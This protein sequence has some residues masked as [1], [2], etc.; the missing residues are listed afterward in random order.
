MPRA[1]SVGKRS[2]QRWTGAAQTRFCV[3]TPA[4]VAGRS[5]TTSARSSRSRSCRTPHLTPAKRK[6]RGSLVSCMVVFVSPR[7]ESSSG[8]LPSKTRVAAKQL[9]LLQLIQHRR[10]REFKRAGLVVPQA[11]ARLVVLQR[12]AEIVLTID[13]HP[14]SVH[15]NSFEIGRSIAVFGFR[16]F[17]VGPLFADAHQDRK[18]TRLN[19]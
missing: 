16:P 19:S 2:R 18:S 10:A 7:P 13:D 14:A 5:L 15:A 3:N 12:T 17:A 8:A 9:L 11:I 4:A 6:P 1:S